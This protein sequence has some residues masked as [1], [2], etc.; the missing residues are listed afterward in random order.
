MAA[1]GAVPSQLTEMTTTKLRSASCHPA[2]Y[3]ACY[4]R[5]WAKKLNHSE[6]QAHLVAAGFTV[7]HSGC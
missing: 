3:P 1:G 4:R 5:R 7:L 2:C 6:A